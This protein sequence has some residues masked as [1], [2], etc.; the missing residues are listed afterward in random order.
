MHPDGGK[1]NKV[2]QTI[3][4]GLTHCANLEFDGGEIILNKMLEKHC[5]KK[6]KFEMRPVE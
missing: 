2:H 4:E 5:S 6:M 3:R 1:C